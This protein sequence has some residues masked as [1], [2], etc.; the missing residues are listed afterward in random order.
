MIN[1][2]KIVNNKM[3]RIKILELLRFVPDKAMVTLQYAL[4]MGRFPNYKKPARYSEIIQLY[5]L[6]YRDNLMRLCADKYTVR[7]YVSKQGFASYLVPIIGVFDSPDDI[8]YSLLKEECFIKC[9]NSSHGN[10]HYIP[11]E[12]D[13]TKVKNLLMSSFRTDFYCL[14]REWAYSDARN[15]IIV[16]AALK[17]DKNKNLDDYKFFCFDGSVALVY[18]C[19]DRDASG[20]G[21]ISLYDRSF[22]KLPVKR[23]G[24]P[25]TS[26]RYRPSNY[27]TMLEMAE[28]LSAPFPHVRVDLYNIDGAIYFGEMTFYTA[29]GYVS[30]DPD[31]FDFTLGSKFPLDWLK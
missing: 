31:S 21:K 4:K 17:P 11:G 16:E 28:K 8:N 22:N 24:V 25:E 10:V 9:T 26:V 15:R 13:S 2:K 3:I 23:T 12:T 5:K 18:V 27:N 1:Y 19:S 14:G 30:F 20:E 29:S 7:E 6:Y